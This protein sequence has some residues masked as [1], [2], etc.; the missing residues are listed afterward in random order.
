MGFRLT[1]AV[2][3]ESRK[4]PG[5]DQVQGIFRSPEGPLGHAQFVGPVKGAIIHI[6]H[7]RCKIPKVPAEWL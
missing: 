6:M 5:V 3:A 2:S 7:A 1:P 4:T